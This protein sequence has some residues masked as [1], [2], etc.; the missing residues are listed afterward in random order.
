MM[1]FKAV[2]NYLVHKCICRCLRVCD[3]GKSIAV[4]GDRLRL[5]SAWWI[6]EC[7][8]FKI[9]L[10]HSPRLAKGC[11]LMYCLSWDRVRVCSS[12]K[13]CNKCTTK[14]D[15]RVS[16]CA[17]GKQV[18]QWKR[19]GKKACVRWYKTEP[20]TL[21]LLHLY[22]ALFWRNSLVMQLKHVNW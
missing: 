1:Y 14:Q 22:L 20:V 7:S 16:L 15:S 3:D 17:L 12:L 5:L 11:S 18:V 19:N 6:A 2:L 9:L 21:T 10:G 13:V 8:C 4:W